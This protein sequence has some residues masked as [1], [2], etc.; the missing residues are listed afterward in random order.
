[1]NTR[2]QMLFA[3]ALL[4]LAA[5][6]DDGVGT[7]KFTT[8]GEEYIEQ[9]IPSD[10]TGEAGFVDGWT[11]HYDKFLVVFH[12]VSVADSGGAI[13]ATMPG[14]RFVDN[15]KPGR[16]DLVSFAD[17]DAKH[18]DRV[19]YQIKPAL[20]DSEV[21]AGDVADRD[22]MVQNGYSVYV[23]GSASKVGA[24]GVSITKTFHWGFKTATQ[25][26]SCQQAAESGQPLEGVVVTNGGTDVSELTTHGD[27]LYYDRLMTSSDPAVKTSLR[28]DEKA[29]ADKNA[30]G[31]VTLDELFATPIDVRKYDPSGLDAPSLGA[32]M[33]SLARTIGHFRGEGECTVSA[34]R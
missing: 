12:N 23:A 20:A 15:T 18:W 34:V 28:F 22:M 33:T 7:A 21:V 26:A 27:H 14:S 9:S 8:W 11:L 24:D 30:D 2:R 3:T 10:P 16:K 13:A 17:L 6:G 19:S 31:E 5:C 4:T 32:F 29:A 25:Y 1:M